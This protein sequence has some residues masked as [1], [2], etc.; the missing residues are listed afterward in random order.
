[1]ATPQEE[2]DAATAAFHAALTEIGVKALSDSLLLWEDV[3]P[4]AKPAV[5][6]RWVRTCLRLVANRRKTAQTLGLAYYR[7][8]RALTTGYTVSEPG[9]ST[10]PVPLDSLRKDFAILVR[11][12]DG[13]QG[14]TP[15]RD[16]GSAQEADRENPSP[17]PGDSE[18]PVE[19][20]ARLEAALKRLE[21]EAEREAQLNLTAL[22]PTY[23]QKLIDLIDLN[24]KA[25]VD[26]AHMQAGARQAASVERL[27]RNG[28]RSAMWA[29]MEDDK[30]AV[31]YVR[32]STTGTPCGWC[33]ML[34]SRGPVYRS[35]KSATL[36]GGAATYEDGDKFHD[37]CHCEAIPVFSLQQ[38]E[39]SSLF[40]LNNKY[41]E[42]WPRVTSGLSGKA[43]VA[44]W[45]LHIKKEQAADRESGATKSNVQE[46]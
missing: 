18:I 33:A 26:G 39:D 6:A 25:T 14:A 30:R 36:K 11:P 16:T 27:V 23:Q 5:V 17:S 7:L 13:P 32:Y 8:S 24:D 41:A 37:N 43:A 3:P 21:L 42:E 44:A 20:L 4:N 29:S 34:I 45:R 40:A 38:Y 31:G 2:T 22:G 10:D 28:A 15:S 46:A 1:M 12:S 9:G 35:E 19:P